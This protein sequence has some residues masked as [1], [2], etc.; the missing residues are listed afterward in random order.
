MSDESFDM[1][2]SSTD[3]AMVVVTTARDG[4]AA[5]CLVGFHSQSSIEPRRY[6]VWL[7]KVNRT[8]R[9]ASR[10]THLG[11]HALAD[12]DRDLAVHFGS[13]T[14]DDVD[15]LAR[16]AWRPG[17][18]GVPLLSDCPSVVVLRRVT[19]LDD[20]GD[21]VCIVG[22]PVHVRSAG[23]VRP[24][25]LSAVSDLRPGHPVGERPDPGTGHRR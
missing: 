7:S 24:L 3:P 6:A 14:G 16:C 10:A 9:I 15:K 21:H 17:P 2:T 5:G 25:R 18:A 4:E 22:K 8:Y 19:L 11:V 12:G 23:R 1:V 13:R 20:G